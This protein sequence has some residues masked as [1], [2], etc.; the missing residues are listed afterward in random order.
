MYWVVCRRARRAAFTLV[1]LLV[2]IA[3]IG[4]LV[5]LLLPAVQQARESARRM[6]CE[7]N[8]RQLGLG[9]H[10]NH[11]VTLTLLPTTVAEPVAAQNAGFP[12]IDEPDG[13]AMWSTLMLPYI[14][15]QNVFA[16]WDLK[17]QTSRQQPQAYQTQI[18]A[19]WC[20]SRLKQVLSLNDFKNP[21]GGLGDYSPSQ[22]TIP[23]VNNA[24]ADGPFI[25]AMSEFAKENGFTIVKKF[26]PRL[27]MANITDGTSNTLMFG[28]KHIRP[29][30]LR[31]K[32]EDRS[33]YGGVNNVNRRVAGIQQ[34]KP[35]DIRPLRPPQDQDGAFANQSFGGPHPG[36]CN[37]VMCDGSIKKLSLNINIQT[38]TSLAT[39]M[40]GETIAEN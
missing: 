13:F 31:G 18:K 8:L 10:N 40:G 34:N 15:Q 6:S 9:A 33:I 12:G 39:R 7:N 1:E 24:N 35:A 37:F 36:V 27:R 30:S 20:P 29:K 19:Y 38:L 16:L 2:V 17:I 25:P 32:N 26:T 4:V 22:G 14:E 11:D 28:E 5:A 3:I 21:G 23:G